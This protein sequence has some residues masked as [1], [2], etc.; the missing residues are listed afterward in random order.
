VRLGIAEAKVLAVG[1][2]LMG[3][4]DLW[5]HIEVEVVGG[6]RRLVVGGIE[7]MRF[8]YVAK[9]GEAGWGCFCGAAARTEALAYVPVGKG[10]RWCT[11]VP[12]VL[13]FLC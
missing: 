11:G 8:V 9:V 10:S 2:L 1:G 7:G 4:F 5:Y 3:F 13:L 6:F 12:R